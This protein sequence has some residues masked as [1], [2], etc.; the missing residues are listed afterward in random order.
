MAYLKGYCSICAK[1]IPDRQYC[2]VGA[3]G[4]D[5][6]FDGFASLS[7]L[8]YAC[9]DCVLPIIPT[10]LE[11]SAFDNIKA[12]QIC[13]KP[14]TKHTR[15]VRLHATGNLSHILP[16]ADVFGCYECVGR[17]TVDILNNHFDSPTSRIGC[18]DCR[19]SKGKH[20]IC[21]LELIKL[22]S[23]GYGDFMFSCYKC[24]LDRF[25]WQRH[26]RDVVL[27]PEN[28]AMKRKSV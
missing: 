18:P 4:Y 8:R 27:T 3:I 14:K 5:D 7:L 24:M 20:T 25:G 16:D 21:V 28:L 26:G 22:G 13:N 23:L 1:I 10:A 9:K 6:F 15:R 11:K 12:C 17:Y 2:S 19:R